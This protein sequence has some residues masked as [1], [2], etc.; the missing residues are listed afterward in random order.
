MLAHINATTVAEY[1]AV[2]VA[3]FTGTTAVITYLDH[4]HALAVTAWRN[5]IRIR[6]TSYTSRLPLEPI[7]LM[8]DHR[9]PQAEAVAHRVACF[10]I[11][12]RSAVAQAISF[13]ERKT[14]IIWPRRIES[15]LVSRGFEMGANTGGLAE[16]IIQGKWGSEPIRDEGIWFDRFYWLRVEA[17]R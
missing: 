13:D 5:P 14:R 11:F 4:R 3:V 9:I 10:Q 6:G 15:S 12:N 16:L 7:R 1:A 2:V 8:V 17:P